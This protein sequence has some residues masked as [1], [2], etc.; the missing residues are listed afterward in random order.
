MAGRISGSAEVSALVP[1]ARVALR[2]SMSVPGK[3]L[4]DRGIAYP[5]T[6]DTIWSVHAPRAPSIRNR[7]RYILHLDRTL[8][9]ISVTHPE[10]GETEY[11]PLSMVKQYR[12]LEKEPEKPAAGKESGK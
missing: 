3:S 10:S 4:P 8:A 11:V 12:V 6:E 5:T 9:A 1:L 2:E 7:D